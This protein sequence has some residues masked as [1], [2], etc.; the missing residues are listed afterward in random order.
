MLKFHDHSL[1][2]NSLGVGLPLQVICYV[3]DQETVLLFVGVQVVSESSTSSVE[4]IQLSV[5]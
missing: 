1:I 4:G 5:N 3:S 2:I